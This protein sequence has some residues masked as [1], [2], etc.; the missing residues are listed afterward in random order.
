VDCVRDAA[1][2]A[3]P[4]RSQFGAPLRGGR[5]VVTIT[6]VAVTVLSYLA[7]LTVGEAWT[8]AIWFWP[9]GGEAEPWRFLTTAL[10]HYPRGTFGIMHILFNMYALWAMGQYL[11][12]ALGRLRFAVVYVLS[13]LGGSVMV[14]L[15]A[16]PTERAWY[17]GVVGAS[18]AVFGLFGAIAVVLRRLG[19]STRP[20]LT[21]VAINGLIGFLVPGIAWQGHLGGLL[22]GAAIGAAFA[23]AP[24]ARRREVG[25]AASVGIAALLVVLA[26]L[27]YASV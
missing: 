15:L 4:A 12:P 6:I 17:T 21:I 22:T 20:I 25:F 7:Q 13:A 11:E 3:R 19:S 5:P 24:R 9:A 26:L 16:S 14:L 8:S 1:R 2:A 10:A 23:Y 18:G 27:K